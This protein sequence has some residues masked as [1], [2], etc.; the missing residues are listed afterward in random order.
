MLL[1]KT[2]TT[3][4][5]LI[6]YLT[7]CHKTT[8]KPELLGWVIWPAVITTLDYSV[9]KWDSCACYRLP[10]GSCGA[11]TL[12]PSA[13]GNGWQ[14]VISVQQQWGGWGQLLLCS[15]AGMHQYEQKK[16]TVNVFGRWKGVMLPV[17]LAFWSWLFCNNNLEKLQPIYKR[18]S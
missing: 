4:F 6:I 17:S 11:P 9:I 12:C 7:F 14:G 18:L 5:C 15:Q 8:N 10:V 16:H 2:D 13:G 3:F 1:L